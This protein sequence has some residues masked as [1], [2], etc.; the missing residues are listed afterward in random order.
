MGCGSGE[1]KVKIVFEKDQYN[2]NV[3][4]VKNRSTGQTVWNC[5]SAGSYCL[6]ETAEKCLASGDYDVVMKDGN[7]DGCPTFQLH[8]ENSS[9]GYTPLITKCFNPDSGDTWTR[10]F[11]TKTISLT[12]RQQEWLTAHNS[13]RYVLFALLV[14]CNCFSIKI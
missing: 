8:M 9:G 13:R 1:K 10:H 11:H 6:S 14:L 7:S 2:E 5:N 3:W 4:Y 12:S